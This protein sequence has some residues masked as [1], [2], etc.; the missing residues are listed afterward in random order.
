MVGATEEVYL[1]RLQGVLLRYSIPEHI[2]IQYTK[3]IKRSMQRERKKENVEGEKKNKTFLL[4]LLF[5]TSCASRMPPPGKPDTDP[6]EIKIVYPQDKDTVYK[7]LQVRY[8]Y[9]DK[10]PLSWIG[11]Y[12]DG[13]RVF[14]DSIKRD[15]I[16]L[17]MDTLPDTIHTIYIEAKDRW[18]NTGKSNIVKIFTVG[19]KRSEMKNEGMDREYKGP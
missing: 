2:K 14:V 9:K 19:E 15:S 16:V 18:D 17:K 8:I 12:I 6:P 4:L 3:I 7:F 5:L 13:R 11:L 10:S 1:V